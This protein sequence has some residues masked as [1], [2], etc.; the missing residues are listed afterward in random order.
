MHSEGLYR[1]YRD[2]GLVHPPLPV[3]VVLAGDLVAVMHTLTAPKTEFLATSFV[4][5]S[6]VTGDNVGLGIWISNVDSK[7]SIVLGS[8]IW[9]KN[10]DCSVNARNCEGRLV[11]MA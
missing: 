1:T 9:G 10:F 11:W 8:D 7:T 6:M 3:D 5:S 4:A 2:E